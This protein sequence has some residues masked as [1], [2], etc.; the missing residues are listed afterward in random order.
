MK[1]DYLLTPYTRINSKCI[2]DL[3]VRLE[4]IILLEENIGSKISDICHSN[5]FFL[6]YLLGQGKQKKKQRKGLHQTENF[7]TAKEVINK[8][9]RQPTE[10]ENIFTNDTSGKE[11]VSKIY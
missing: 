9:K 7:C 11:I 6:I 3:N 4:A 8:M 2:K 1:L 10:W 5:I